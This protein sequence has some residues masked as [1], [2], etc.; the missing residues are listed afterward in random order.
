MVIRMET[1]KTAP[2]AAITHFD[3]FGDH[4]EVRA[5]ARHPGVLTYPRADGS[6]QRELVTRDLLFRA[7]SDGFPA[8]AAQLADLPITND[9][10]PELLHGDAQ[11]EDQ[12]G[13]GR[14]KKRIEVHQKGD[15]EVVLH[16]Y[17]ADAIADIKS[18]RKTGVSLGYTCG[19]RMDSGTYEGQRYD[20][21]QDEPFK[22]DHLAICAI[23]RADKA[24]I[25]FD[26][27]TRADSPVVIPEEP[28]MA[29]ITL[30]SVH[31]DQIPTE[32]AAAMNAVVVR[33]DQAESSLAALQTK[34]DMLKKDMGKYK[35]MAEEEEEKKDSLAA[36]LD[37]E[38]ERS[39]ALE[40]KVAELEAA[41]TDS[42]SQEHLDAISDELAD[43][44]DAYNAI[45]SKLGPQMG[46]NRYDANLDVGVVENGALGYDPRMDSSS[47]HQMALEAATGEKFDGKSPDYIRGRF[48]TWVSTPGATQQQP[49]ARVD[50]TL[51]L[52]QSL[53]RAGMGADVPYMSSAQIRQD[54]LRRDQAASRQRIGAGV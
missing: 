21:V 7:D 2:L 31:Y 48:D 47:I 37:L 44:L 10:P 5:V 24:W 39:D 53:S 32:A 26:D 42:S 50:S 17:K 52:R 40:L 27:A 36:E 4:L 1:V 15:T 38:M 51:A 18:G 3:D 41:R 16:V 14:T 30:G 22:A 12:Y 25:K 20:V 23:P 8:I 6:I 34:F 19:T 43:R 46:V 35:D 28:Y 13:V 54:Q 11:K 9:H 29:S 33:A 49:H 45:M